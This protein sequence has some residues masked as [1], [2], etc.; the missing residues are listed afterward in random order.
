MADIR[1]PRGRAPKPIFKP[2]ITKAEVMGKEAEYDKEW[3]FRRRVTLLT[4]TMTQAEL[5][6]K[7]TSVE[8]AKAHLAWIEEVQAYLRHLKTMTE[9]AEAA[10]ARLLFVALK[11]QEAR[12]GGAA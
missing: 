8:A 1:K 4:L 10:Q 9:L 6:S 3:G 2:Q 11:A 12:Q 5:M 7:L